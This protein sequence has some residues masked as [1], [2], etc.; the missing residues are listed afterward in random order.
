MTTTNPGPATTSSPNSFLATTPPNGTNQYYTNTAT[1]AVTVLAAQLMMG[2]LVVLNMTGTLGAGANLTTDTASNMAVNLP[3]YSLAATAT[4]S[5]V[6][7]II[8]SSSGAFSWTVVAGTGVTLTGTATIAQNTWREFL[9][10]ISG[11]N[12]VTM[13]SIGTG[14]YS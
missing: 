1:A 11:G 13:Q 6:L 8:N 9:V 7:R 5:Y 2:D 14:T 10:T 4:A 3:N 12:A